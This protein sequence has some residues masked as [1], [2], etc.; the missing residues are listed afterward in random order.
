MPH[1]ELESLALRF[2]PGGGPVQVQ[3]MARGLVNESFL[4]RRDGRRFVMRVATN[5]STDLGQDR[6]WECRV[7]ACAAKAGLAPSIE[8]CEVPDGVLISEW[9]ECR[10]WT[11]EEVGLP[12]NV[13]AM[14]KLL[15]RVHAL[16]VPEP[17]RMMNPAAWVRHYTVGLTGHGPEIS[18]RSRALRRSA[19]TRL[20]QLS[21]A[22]PAVLC[23]SD[24]HRFNVAVGPGPRERLLLLDWEYAHVADPYWD[25]AGWAANNDWTGASAT[26]WLAAY[27]GRPAL[28]EEAGRLFLWMWLYDYVCLLWSELYLGRD[29]DESTRGVQERGETLCARLS[30]A[31]GSRA[32]EVPAH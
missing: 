15:R 11:P 23:H 16:P 10:S 5:R 18:H 6:E 28:P 7:L 31:P 8:C 24:L 30:S 14:A 17:A 3:P 22:A 19:D 26:G 4:V 13:A 27:L 2:A 32:G 21:G 9:V 1:H 12:D 29:P 25:L 20:A